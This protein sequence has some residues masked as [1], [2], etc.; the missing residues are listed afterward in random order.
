VA[1]LAGM[2]RHARLVGHALHAL[3][4]TTRVPWHRVVNVAGRISLRRG[5]GPAVQRALLER[6]G[7]TFGPAGAIRL[8]RFAW[9][10]RT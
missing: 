4:D 3:P 5:A 6:E 2:P 10:P 7:V 9:R 1:A 8:D